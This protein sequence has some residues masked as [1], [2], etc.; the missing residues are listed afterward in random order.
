LEKGSPRE[1]AIKASIVAS[2]VIC[3]I[4][5]VIASIKKLALGFDFYLVVSFAVFGICFAVYYY[6]IE[7]FIYR[8][9][10]LIYKTINRL[11]VDKKKGKKVDMNSD[12]LSEVN[13]EVVTWAQSKSKE[14]NR[15]KETEIYRKEF[16]GNLSHELKTPI[17]SIQGYILTLLE[18][19]MDDPDV[20]ERFL[21]KASLS[22]ERMTTLID[23]LD[24]LIKLETSG[25]NLKLSLFNI[26]QS[27]QDI[28]ES[29]DYAAK[30]K[31]ITLKIKNKPEEPIWVNADQAKIEQVITNLVAN[32]INYGN[33]NGKTVVDIHD[34]DN[35]IMIEIADN[36]IGISEKYLPRIFERFYRV[37]K[38]RTRHEGGS[39]LGL[40]I[41]KHIIEAHKQRINATST[42]GEGSSFNF[43][44]D[45]GKK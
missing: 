16:I 10:K 40:A 37:D 4:I 9:I 21:T 14:I 30:K 29:I 22:V 17:F 11:K 23:D 34:M 41:V 8:K 31:N 7:Y 28:F 18:G 13:Q 26:V 27:I 42:E 12:V 43:T 33:E 35:K 2:L 15:L 45:K 32:S 39:G 6:A 5:F 1:I 36:G 3:I 44:L 38:S 20:A 19:A 24:A 25:P